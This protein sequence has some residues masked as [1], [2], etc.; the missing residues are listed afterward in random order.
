MFV[1]PAF[2][3]SADAAAAPGLIESLV[4]FLL[5]FVVFYF[6]LIRPQQKKAKEHRSMQESVRRGD[7]II[8]NGGIFGDV[9]RVRDDGVVEV[10]IAE[11]VKVRVDRGMISTVLA[12]TEPAGKTP[13][14]DANDNDG[15][16]GAD[17]SDKKE[18]GG[19]L[20]NLLSGKK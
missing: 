2:A 10:E 14:G 16:K 9:V 15:G 5:I 4:P 18:S 17:K 11:G 13:K 12:K 19:G 7:K 3:Q 1:S 8:T 20:K 6:L